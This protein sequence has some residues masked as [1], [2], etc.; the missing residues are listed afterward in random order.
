MQCGPQ[1]HAGL[2]SRTCIAATAQYQDPSYYMCT[3]LSLQRLAAYAYISAS[4][5]PAIESALKLVERGATLGLTDMI[6]ATVIMTKINHMAGAPIFGSDV[7][8]S[9]YPWVSWVSNVS[10]RPCIDQFEIVKWKEREFVCCC[11]NIQQQS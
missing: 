9:L 4:D 3:D 5:A 8:V 11:S 2:I 7:N 6:A 1:Q 10:W